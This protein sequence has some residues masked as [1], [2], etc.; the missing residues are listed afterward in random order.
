MTA[1]NMRCPLGDRDVVIHPL[2]EVP[3]ADSLVA[4]GHTLLGLDVETTSF[5]PARMWGPGPY[6]DGWHL[7]LVQVATETEAWL[8][9]PD[10]PETAEFL[11]D[12][13]FSFVSHTDTD[14]VAIDVGL[15]IKLYDR[16]IDTYP[17]AYLT[18]RKPGTV[19]LKRLADDYG[20]PE[21]QQADEA[22]DALFGEMVSEA[23]LVLADE[24]E[25][26]GFTRGEQLR[27]A[28]GYTHVDILSPDYQRYSGLDAAAVRRLL[29]LMLA[30]VSA[31]RESVEAEMAVVRHNAEHIN[32]RGV[33]VDTALLAAYLD[34]YPPA[35]EAAIQAF[36]D[37]TGGV[38]PNSAKQ[39][40]EYWTREGVTFDDWA[41]YGGPVSKK[42]GDPS[43]GKDAWNTLYMFPDLTEAGR[44][45]VD[46]YGEMLA[47]KNYAITIK[48]LAAAV[49][50]DGRIHPQIN[51]LG[52]DT[53]RMSSRAPNC[54]NLKGDMRK[55]IIPDD[56][57][58]L[59]SIDID[60]L[61][62][63]MAAAVSQDP[64]LIADT[65][66]GADMHQAMADKLGI[67]RNSAKTLNYQTLFGGGAKAV[68]MALG[69]TYDEARS[70]I[71]GWWASYSELS[72]LNQGLKN[73]HDFI[74]AIDGRRIAVPRYG[75][76]APQPGTPRSYANINYLIQSAS[77]MLFKTM[78]LYIARVL[79]LGDR[80]LLYVHDE[81]ILQVPAA[82]VDETTQLLES[83][84]MTYRHVEFTS[85][86]AA[87]YDEK[88]VSRWVK[89]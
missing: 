7:R 18:G 51:T 42:T 54:Q 58:V 62:A 64:A 10:Q 76:D 8:M 44:R 82:D 83:M 63:K 55:I 23:G 43:L 1:T 13:R 70:L 60:S 73:L 67:D 65:A 61:E 78:I 75:K 21:L 20:M 72:R 26:H 9:L 25:K 6:D 56:G 35:Y 36:Q 47:F 37:H 12:G 22:L 30:E 80:I 81:L 38:N 46:L 85:G 14:P 89:S 68:A 49:G 84:Q 66:P 34:R 87:L 3:D 39:L 71:I 45:A 86:V 52:T 88:G 11:R 17:I 77:A 15:G 4:A 74:P 33:K 48:Q 19:G 5:G 32:A 59:L 41:A 27:A 31:P 16:W 29:P 24:K 28:W 69:K 40:R 79:G 57:F 53:G 50:R 2:S